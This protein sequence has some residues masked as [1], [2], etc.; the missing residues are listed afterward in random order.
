[1]DPAKRHLQVVPDRA[2]PLPGDEIAV[3]FTSTSGL[4]APLRKPLNSFRWV[5]P[6]TLRFDEQGILVTGKSLTML[7]LRPT[8]RF[9]PPAE[10]RDVY[11]EGSE[12]LVQLRGPRNPYFRFWAEDATSAAQIVAHLPTR[13]TIEFEG[14]L[15]EARTPA[16]N[17][18]GGAWIVA[19]LTVS[20]LAALAWL[21]AGPSAR[22]A[23]LP[24][25]Q[26]A[27]DAPAMAKSTHLPQGALSPEDAS[28]ARED[29]TKYGDRIEALRIEFA[30]AFDALMDGKVSQQKFADELQQWLLPQWDDLESKLRRANAAPGS[31]QELADDHLM[32]AINNWQLA[33]RAYTDDLRNQRQVVSTFEYLGRAERHESRAQEIL[34]NLERR[35]PTEGA[36]QPR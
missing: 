8:Q 5:G 30:T 18:A 11:R 36:A 15:Q 3:R 34:R 19:L 32:A 26:P 12:V 10:I 1:M 16:A 31:L 7:G 29:L 9:I 14:T 25:L 21:E 28:L 2:S 27:L 17:R 23:R 4:V 6:G 13:R 35:A 22:R 24:V 33:L 20:G